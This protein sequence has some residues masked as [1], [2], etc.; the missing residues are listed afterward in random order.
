MRVL[1]T[2]MMAALL[3]MAVTGAAVAQP[4]PESARKQMHD[5][6]RAQAIASHTQGDQRRAMIRSCMQAQ[7]PH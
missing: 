6:C 7:R 5:T 3:V 4:V 1:T 2:P